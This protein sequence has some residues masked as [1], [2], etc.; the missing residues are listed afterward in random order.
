[1][2]E[3]TRIRETESRA[4]RAVRKAIRANAHCVPGL[5]FRDRVVATQHDELSHKYDQDQ[6]QEVYTR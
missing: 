5:L 6:P 3:L 2:S 4:V 1:M